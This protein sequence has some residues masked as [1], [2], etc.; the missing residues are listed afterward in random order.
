M[1]A[2]RPEY[3]IPLSLI[4]VLF[5][6]LTAICAVL[7]IRRPRQ[8]GAWLRRLLMVLLLAVVAV[9]PVTP[10]EGEQTTRMN[11]DV[12]FL[13]DLTGSMA[14]ED[15]DGTS[16]RLDGVKA[17]MRQVMDMTQGARYSIIAFD[18]SATQQLPLT[19][20]AGAAEAWIDTARTEPTAYSQGSNVDRGLQP[21]LQSLA[22]TRREDP[23]SQLLVYMLS[24]GENTDGQD[25]EPFD[26]VRQYVAGGGVLGYGTLEGGPMKARG[27]QNDGQYLTG[28]DGQQARSMIDEQQLQAIAQ[29]MGVPYLHRTAP[30]ESL[31]ETMAGITLKPVPIRTR[32]RAPSFQDWYWVAA[33]PLAVLFIWELGATTYRLPRR[34]ERRDFLARN[35]DRS[36]R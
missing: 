18:S 21:L 27:G 14:A 28:D 34:V 5:V 20:D 22:D 11:A 29:Q 30:G 32:S 31:E 36:E 12:F 6:P 7:L 25:T 15:Y 23:D 2:L 19:T 4:L 8:R 16:P 10:V 24:D 33:I 13:V 1:S 35:D 26:A 3:L 9:R 17:D